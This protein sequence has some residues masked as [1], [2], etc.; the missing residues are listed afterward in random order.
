MI[1]DIFLQHNNDFDEDWHIEITQIKYV[2]TSYVHVKTGPDWGG[3]GDG[4]FQTEGGRAY[5]FATAQRRQK[6]K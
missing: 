1:S 5:N 6:K 4:F 2:N 3:D